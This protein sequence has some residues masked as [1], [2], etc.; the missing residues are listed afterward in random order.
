MT[1]FSPREGLFGNVVEIKVV[2]RMKIV[3]GSCF[4]DTWGKFLGIYFGSML[5]ER[6]T[7]SV[8]SIWESSYNRYPLQ[9]PKNLP[10]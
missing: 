3:I 8:A 5:A 9:P 6:A 7:R 10:K 1:K 2:G 4:W